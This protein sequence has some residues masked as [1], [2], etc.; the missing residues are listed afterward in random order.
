MAEVRLMSTPPAKPFNWK[1]LGARVASGFVLVPAVLGAIW[2]ERSG[3]GVV[4]MASIAAGLLAY[5]W[6][7]MSTDRGRKRV[8]TVI[9]LA[10]IIPVVVAHFGNRD[11]VTG[12]WSRWALPT[13]WSLAALG[14]IIAA[15]AAK[16]ALERRADAFYGVVY[17]APPCIALVWLRGTHQGPEWTLLLF[18]TTW[19]AD[20]GA[21]AFGNILKGPKLWPRFSP[22][23]TWAGFFGGL[24]CGAIAAIVV[25]RLNDMALTLGA[26]TLMGLAGALATMAGDLWESVLKRR[27]GVKDSGD[28]IPGHGGLLD[29]VDG[30]LFAVIVVCAVRLIVLVG[31]AR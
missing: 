31:W 15:L 25:W 3:W 26:A 11:P 28:I 18:M 5:E 24:L 1:N 9:A 6:A 22:N 13:A 27:F 17:I 14:A 21:Y 7:V 2:W 10:V 8:M 30:L 16:G 12:M 19:F 29:R 4:A 20:T 23:K